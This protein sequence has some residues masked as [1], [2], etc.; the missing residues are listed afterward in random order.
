MNHKQM[1]NILIHMFKGDPDSKHWLALKFY[2]STE[3]HLI[4]KIPFEKVSWRIRSYL[5]RQTPQR[6]GG[7]NK[8]SAYIDLTVPRHVG[9]RKKQIAKHMHRKT[10]FM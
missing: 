3:I 2:D 10:E 8:K 1:S 7:E 9:K 6:D 5:K 4:D